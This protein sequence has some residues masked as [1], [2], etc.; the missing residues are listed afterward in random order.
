MSAAPDCCELSV[1]SAEY[2]DEEV[3]SPLLSASLR[4]VPRSLEVLPVEPVDLV[5]VEALDVEAACAA[6][7]R[8]ED[9]AERLMATVLL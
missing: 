6:A 9:M 1:T 8:D 4:A 7:R 2:S 3:V 5:V